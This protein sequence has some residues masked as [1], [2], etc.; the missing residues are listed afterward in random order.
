MIPEGPKDQVNVEKTIHETVRNAGEIEI[1]FDRSLRDRLKVVLM[2]DN[3]GWSME[4]YVQVVQTLFDYA[5]ASFKD[6]KTFF[7][8]NT[9][10]DYV[11]ADPPRVRRPQKVDDLARFDPETRLIMVGD[12]SMAPYELM[13]TDGSIHIE[14]RTS[15]PSLERLRQ[16]TETFP[17]SVW[18]N[19]KGMHEWS[20]TRTIG[21]I[22]K[23]FPM[24]ELT[25]DGLEKAVGHLVAKH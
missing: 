4:P 15:K 2:I 12:A 23:L 25:L 13:S 10:Y 11:W 21:H 3:G 9:I 18:L 8:H 5:R 6:V 17:H 14:E 20:W 24:Y 1:V 19:P 16:L 22:A 7:F